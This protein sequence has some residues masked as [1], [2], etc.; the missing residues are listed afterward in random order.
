MI[1][2]GKTLRTAREA[3]GLTPGQIAERTHMMVQVVEGL[4]NENFS[5]IVA[6]I[7]GRGF[8][9]LY[10]EAVGLEPKPLVEAFMEIYSGRGTS[11]A[12]SAPAPAS[13][14]APK[15]APVMD[16]PP[17]QAKPVAPEPPARVQSI[18]DFDAPAKPVEPGKPAATEPAQTVS[19]YAAPMP[20]DD[21]FSMPIVNWRM[22]ALAAAAV[23][24]L[25]IAI[26][27]VRALYRVTMTVPEEEQTTEVTTPAPAP[28]PTPTPTPT[29]TQAPA[30]VA[31][32]RKPLPLKPF[33]I[34]SNHQT[35][36]EK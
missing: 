32:D 23:V 16:T 6:P 27:G 7:Y 13:S 21:G 10:C 11:A 33:Y 36:T 8:V 17:E 34:D 1:E 15:P 31:V 14:P 9:K 28:T 18:I 26:F 29:E 12:K 35:E 22:V 24:I 2:F 4:E 3:K 30:K 5:K 20:T 19:R 25:L